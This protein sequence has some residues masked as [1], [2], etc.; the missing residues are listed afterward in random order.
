MSKATIS[1]R[2]ERLL[3]TKSGNRCAKC[4]EI[5]VEND[6]CIGENA[7]IFG[8]KPGAA[9]YDA[10]K[11]AAYVN[12]EQ[13]LIFL[14]SNC[15][16]VVD[17]DVSRYTTEVLFSMK[18]EH[19][20]DVRAEKQGATLLT[21]LPERNNQFSG[22]DQNTYFISYT[23]KTQNNIDWAKWVEWVLRVELGKS[24]IMQEYDFRPGDNFKER[25]NNALKTANAVVCI[26]TEEYMESANCTEEWTN[27]DYFIPIRFDCCNPRGLLKSRVYIDL[28]GLDKNTLKEKL[29]NSLVG[30]K[31]PI[32]EPPLPALSKN[33]DVAHD[34][35]GFPCTTVNNLPDRNPNFTG[36]EDY[37]KTICNALTD[38]P[39]FT[40][41]G[42]GGF[43][44][45]QLA[46]EYA[47]KHI[48]EYGHVWVVNAESELKLAR[49]YRMFAIRT[50]LP[51]A[52]DL[53]FKDVLRHCMLW[54]ERNS[55]FLFIYDNAEGLGKELRKY[56]PE[57]TVM[58]H[59]IIVSREDLKI[60]HE[61]LYI[62]VFSATRA[63]AFLRN[64][65][66]GTNALAAVSFEK[67]ALTLVE[68]LGR[69][70]LALE[71]TA[72]YMIEN[73][74]TCEGYMSLW[75]V[76]KKLEVLDKNISHDDPKNL[77]AKTWQISIGKVKMASA[78]QFFNLCAYFAPDDIPFNVFLD[79]RGML[80]DEL[81]EAASIGRLM[82]NDIIG[83]LKQYSLIDFNRY[84]DKEIL[85]SIHRLIQEVMVDEHK[86][87]RDETWLRSCLN[88]AYTAFKCDYTNRK[89]RDD[90][91][92]IAPHIQN[93]AKHAEAI[94]NDDDAKKKIAWL[95]SEVG[96]G[97]YYSGDYGTALEWHHKALAIREK[98]LG[99]EHPDTA[100]SY[101]NIA[102]VY[103]SQSDYGTALEWHRKALAIREKVLGKEHPDT[104]ASYNN[105]AL[106]YYRQ[107]DYGTALEWHH[108]ALAIS[109]KV[110]GEEHPSTAESYNNIASVYY[111]QG[112][113]GTALEWHHKALTIREK[114]LGEEHPSTAASY[115][116]I[117]L[118]YYS[119]GDY[120]KALELYLKA[121]AIR[122]KAL[123]EEHPST[124]VSYDN[125]ASVY[126]N[127]GDYGTALEW[128]HKALAI[129]E[130]VLGKEHPSTAESYNNIASVYCSQ[131]DYGKA[132]ELYSKC[133]P[134]ML[135]RL[136]EK[137]PK[138]ITVRSNMKSAYNS[139]GMDEPFEQWLQRQVCSKQYP[140][141]SEAGLQIHQQHSPFPCNK[142]CSLWR[143]IV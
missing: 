41:I 71:H 39:K 28:W 100:E 142:S 23:T 45:T 111:S 92:K 75:S 121:L 44:K 7:H 126:Y 136:G 68:E 50:G 86:K 91:I 90:F 130:K 122:E 69:L 61:P 128:H 19:E 42:T 14:C 102:C 64:R 47:H 36:R 57:G 52:D 56:M 93:I 107:G 118:V 6:A 83:E 137:H 32:N 116:N 38:S 22:T 112:D 82:H 65:L 120:V 139:A 62:K 138:T 33:S 30:T 133:Y 77:I 96:N 10:S 124:A 72:A 21:N 99:K 4:K 1:K 108:K 25:M 5:L 17:R 117:A 132:L 109:E 79:G 70:P 110:L 123:G 58:G 54:L 106:V 3:H 95:H 55:R 66:E 11:P 46:I 2:D 113:Y 98:V 88:M 63:V 48:Q 51:T 89:S 8:E 119:Q 103:D 143:G 73:K 129:S 37:L 35:P 13:N 53:E 105:I 60:T 9:R 125:I 101:N 29:I 31:R 67:D 134:I 131:G 27:A 80:P 43:G 141:T 135:Q 40:I 114:A 20:S 74:E 115:S 15:H 85:I 59:I 87:S 94:L 81:Q 78:F 26:L 34:E 18:K 84:G 140:Q 97:F 76:N 104:A 24:T 12:S 49:S 16:I 127:Q